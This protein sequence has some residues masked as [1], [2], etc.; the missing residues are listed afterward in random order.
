MVCYLAL[1]D[2]LHRTTGGFGVKRAE[3]GFIRVTVGGE[4]EVGVKDRKKE[5]QV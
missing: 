5:A 4:N 3:G 2:Q 1:T